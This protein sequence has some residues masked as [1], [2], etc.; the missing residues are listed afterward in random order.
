MKWFRHRSHKGHPC[1]A[2]TV[3]RPRLEQLEDRTAPSATPLTI[4]TDIIHSVENFSNFVTQQYNTLLHR[5]PDAGGLASWVGG[6]LHGL[7]YEQVEAAIASSPEYIANHGGLG[8]GWVTALY[9]DFL[10]HA[11]DPAGLNSWVNNGLNRGLSPFTIASDIITSVEHETQV[12]TQDYQTFLGRVPSQSEINQWLGG[13][14]HGLTQEGLAADILS[15]AEFYLDSGGTD[16]NLIESLYQD[17][18]GRL[19]A[20]QEIDPWLGLLGDS[21]V[22]GSTQILTVNLNP[23]DLNLLGLEVKTSQIQVN[24][25]AQS[26]QGQL[27]G[28]LLT[29]VANL[30]NLQGVNSALNNVLGNVVSLLNATSLSVTGVAATGPLATPPAS[31]STLGAN[32]L[33]VLNLSVAPIHLDL[34]GALVDTSP[35]TVQIIAHPGQGQ[36]LGNLVYD[37]ANLFNPPLPPSLTL[38]DINNALSNLLSEL[39]TATGQNVTP[40]PAPTTP[41]STQVL[42]LTVPPIN[43]NLLGLILQTSTIQVNATAQTGNG[44]LLGNV[45]TDLLNTLGATPQDLSTLNA[46]LNALLAEVVNVLNSTSLTLPAGAVSSLSQVLQELALPNLITSNTNATAQVLNLVIASNNGTPPVNVDL[47]GLDITTSNIQAQLLAQ[48][49]NGNILGNLVYNVA[50]LLNPGGPV[51]LLTILGQLGV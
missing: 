37:L 47:L 13:F 11:P 18:L 48:T 5:A 27:L 3:H 45:L 8:A 29:D 19:P 23:I 40:T 34:L 9:N 28:N 46:N 33:T 22:T 6:L 30:L 21:I 17:V 38:A 50:N 42:S 32:G 51:S 20:A 26:G 35:I 14:A 25:S 39:G 7:S 4:A 49:G 41:G 2:V 10:G 31:A 44:L 1:A 15:S 43:L 36:I 12:I 16:R 24:V